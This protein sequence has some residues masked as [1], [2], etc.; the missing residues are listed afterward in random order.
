MLEQ[1]IFFGKKDTGKSGDTGIFWTFRLFLFQYWPC[2]HIHTHTYTHIHTHTHTYTHI[3]THTHTHS[4]TTHSPYNGKCAYCG[5]GKNGACFKKKTG[6]RNVVLQSSSTLIT[7]S[8]CTFLS[9]SNDRVSK[10]CYQLLKRRQPQLPYE[11]A[12]PVTPVQQ[13]PSPE[14]S[15]VPP[16]LLPLMQTITNMALMCTPVTQPNTSSS[17]PVT[18]VRT[19]VGLLGLLSR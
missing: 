8:T 17:T 13:V 1:I 9:S 7:A 12:P 14:V 18:P 5:K 15:V 3:H 10:R 6:G 4:H 2:T 19:P 16:E 11:L